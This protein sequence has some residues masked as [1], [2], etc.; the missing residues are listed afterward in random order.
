MYILFFY[1]DIQKWHLLSLS[2]LPRWSSPVWL[3][4]NSAKEKKVIFHQ[5]KE[6]KSQMANSE[7]S[8]GSLRRPYTSPLPVLLVGLLTCRS[9]HS[10]PLGWEKII[11]VLCGREERDI[12]AIW[13]GGRAPQVDRKRRIW[14]VLKSICVHSKGEN[15]VVWWWGREWGREE[16]IASGHPASLAAAEL[17]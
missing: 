13:K 7:S 1:S 17:F 11:K 10:E 15:E 9:G 12:R 8:R 6:N 3:K 16:D 2:H 5:L 4:E 14:A